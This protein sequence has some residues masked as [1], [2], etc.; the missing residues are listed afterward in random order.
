M[1][2]LPPKCL[3]C[4]HPLDEEARYCP[5]CGQKRTD[6]RLTL[7]ELLREFADAVFNIDS[8]FFRTLFA[9]FVP[10]KLTV[11]YFRGRH[12][13]YVH[14]LRVFL[15]LIVGLIAVVTFQLDDPDFFGLGKQMDRQKERH[16]RILFL[17]RADSLIETLHARF[18]QPAAQT[19]LD[20]LRQQLIGSQL[21]SSDDSLELEVSSDLLDKELKIAFDDLDL[22]E[23]QILERYQIEGF[24]DR[25][26]VRQ[27]LRLTKRGENFGVYLLGNASWMMFLMMPLLAL[28]LKLLY[29]RRGFY[30]VEHLVFSFHTHSFYFL[31]FIAMI[32]LGPLRPGLILP[33]LSIWLMV[34][35]YLAMRRVYRQGRIKTFVK[36]F[37]LNGLYMMLF[38]FSLVLTFLVSFALF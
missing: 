19:A 38:T 25:L 37:L 28:V 7:G 20:S 36:Y 30:F 4:Y 33:L 16:H 31:M 9:L 29:I 3:N 14:P 17:T 2:E 13:S 6:G 1:P 35:L 15:V 12:R 32:L 5:G 10:G 24:F 23:D 18:P 22:P 21:Q 11:E 27:E 26:L 34:Y 8:R